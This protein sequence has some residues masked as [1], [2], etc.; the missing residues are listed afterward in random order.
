MIE[1]DD[2][3][4]REVAH[5][6]FLLEQRK[7]KGRANLIGYLCLFIA[8]GVGIIWISRCDL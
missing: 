7:Q 5:E 8:V 3:L 2:E 4:L 1:Y 6:R